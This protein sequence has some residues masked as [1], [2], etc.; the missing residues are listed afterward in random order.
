MTGLSAFHIVLHLQLQAGGLTVALAV[1]VG[2]LKPSKGL[3]GV[4][5]SKRWQRRA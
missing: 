4:E 2:L 5:D 1:A 3:R